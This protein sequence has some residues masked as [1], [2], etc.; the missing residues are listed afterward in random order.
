MNVPEPDRDN[1]PQTPDSQTVRVA[2]RGVS[3]VGSRLG[4][5]RQRWITLGALAIGCC[6]F[7]AATWDRDGSA[8]DG[9]ERGADDPARQ[10]VPFEP[11]RRAVSP[12][13]ADADL[14]ANAPS[15]E[16]TGAEQI[17][18][19]DGRGQDTAGPGAGPSQM[20][21][22]AAM[23]DSARRA[24]L[25]AWRRSGGAGLPP[26]ADPPGPRPA[27]GGVSV[28]ALDDLRRAGPV[29]RAS[30]GQVGDRNLLITAG[31][32][33]PCVL[34]TALD[35]A[36]PGYVVCQVPNDVY[37]DNG[38]VV[39]MERGTRVLGE[40]RGGLQQGRSRLFVLWTRA[41]TPTG[42]S[43]ALASPAADALGRAGFGGSVDTH[44][45]ARFGG[46]LL[47][48]IVDDGGNAIGGSQDNGTFARA[49]SDA[50]ATAL[51]SSINIPATLRKD[52]G[53]EVSIFVAQD[54]DFT[55]VYRL[56]PR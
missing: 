17:P 34:Q 9:A 55:G 26:E 27:A 19:L 18:A 42:V 51:Q 33:V 53:A 56:R 14:D 38:A 43:I 7:L 54:L 45:W 2:D 15:L 39:L 48:S 22:R 37:S 49:P 21:D 23:L 31:A 32:A 25:L 46:A 28:T 24:P 44:F 47:L 20:D 10:V 16:V 13:I 40:Y 11:A 5:A 52:Q 8:Q 50:A 36:T 6:A 4:G 1:R 35:S 41:V 12:V 30:A 3:P 29:G